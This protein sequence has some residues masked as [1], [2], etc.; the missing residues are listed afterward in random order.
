MRFF[1]QCHVGNPR[2]N[3]SLYLSC[4]GKSLSNSCEAKVNLEL[5][6]LTHV[7]VSAL[8]RLA[9]VILCHIKTL[10]TSRMG[11]GQRWYT[12]LMP[13]RRRISEFEASLAYRASSR[14]ARATKKNKK[15]LSQQQ[16]KRLCPEEI[17]FISRNVDC[18]NDLDSHLE[19]ILFHFST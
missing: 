14:T 10:K 17:Q 18:T 16:Q 1:K 8:G 2:R 13:A 6:M 19:L 4:I 7:L 12:P 3:I 5:G 11:A 9:K 15:T